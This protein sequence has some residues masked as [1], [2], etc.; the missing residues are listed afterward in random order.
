MV[1]PMKPVNLLHCG[2]FFACMAACVAADSHPKFR[3]WQA[4]HDLGAKGDKGAVVRLIQELDA[5][6]EKEPGDQLAR[7][8]LGSAYTLRSRDAPIG[9]GK[10][11]ILKKGGATM[12][13]AVAS[14]PDDARV[15]MVRAANSI[16][17]PRIFGRRPVAI[18]DGD[19]LVRILAS[20]NDGLSPE[21]R[22]AAY[23]F[24]GIAARLAGKKKDAETLFQKAL[25]QGPDFPLATEVRKE[26]GR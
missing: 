17:L 16:R 24:A 26:L 20:G 18:A 13:A 23:Y 9:P 3:E 15:R 8:Y 22:Q 1:L 25:E 4:A 14:A 2:L 11:E 7:V 21:E 5:H 10:L 6:L 12:D 19:A